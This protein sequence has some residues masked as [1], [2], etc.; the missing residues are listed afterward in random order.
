MRS[1]VAYGD[2]AQIVS[3]RVVLQVC[4][5]KRQARLCPFLVGAQV[6]ER[7]AGDGFVAHFDRGTNRRCLY[8]CL[9]TIE[10]LAGAMT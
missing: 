8:D 9:E 5:E 6:G 1:D 4:I 7:E 2:I 10:A 3:R